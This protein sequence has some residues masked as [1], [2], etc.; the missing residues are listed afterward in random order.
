MNCLMIY[1]HP[2]PKSFC[3]AILDVLVEEFKRFGQNEIRIRDL[4]A[5]GFDPVLRAAD[6]EAFAGGQVPR[7]IQI[8]QEHILWAGRLIWIYPLWWQG[9]PAVMKGYVDRVFVNGFAH[10]EGPQG[11]RGLLTDKQNFWI[12]TMGA[13]TAVY[14][15][16]GLMRSM[17]QTIDDGIGGYCGMPSLGHKYFGNI[18]HATDEERRG[19]LEEVRR[20]AQQLEAKKK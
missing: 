12:T 7:D 11:P 13:P 5:L 9:L 15:T 8:E 6:F 14:E 10:E 17:Q 18:G 1:C 2:N 19:M 20:I 16:L 3:R 4:Y